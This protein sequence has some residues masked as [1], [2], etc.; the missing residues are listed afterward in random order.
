MHRKTQFHIFAG[1]VTIE[2]PTVAYSHKASLIWLYRRPWA[3]EIEKADW[4]MFFFSREMPGIEPWTS[5]FP[6][7]V[8]DRTS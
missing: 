7:E 3:A 2:H 8:G 1:H 6:N 4:P 5:C